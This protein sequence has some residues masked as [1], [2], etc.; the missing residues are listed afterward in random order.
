MKRIRKLQLNLDMTGEKFDSQALLATFDGHSLFSIFTG[1]LYL[2]QAMLRYLESVY[3]ESTKDG[4]NSTE[5][6]ILRSLVQ[7]LS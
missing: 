7:I 2:F 5:N 3:S 6:P 4:D 1:E